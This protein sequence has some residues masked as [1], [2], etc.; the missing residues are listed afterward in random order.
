MVA[1]TL[2]LAYWFT[3]Y[4]AGRG[5]AGGAGGKATGELCVLAQLGLGKGQRLLVIR[6]GQ[7][8]LLLGVAAES[9]SLLTELTEE[10][11]A[12]WTQGA[13]AAPQSPAFLEAMRNIM[14]QKK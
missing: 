14:S 9:I 12:L 10:E 8:C 5:F 7:R 13:Q 1:A 2:F 6:L 4:V 11:A 3:K